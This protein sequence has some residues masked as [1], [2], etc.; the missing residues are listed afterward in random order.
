MS[1]EQ[2]KKGAFEEAGSHRHPRSEFQI[3]TAGLS[4]TKREE[5]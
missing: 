3:V 5:I 4:P 1:G 2:I